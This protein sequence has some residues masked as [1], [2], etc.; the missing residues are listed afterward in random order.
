MRFGLTAC[1]Y[2][3]CLIMLTTAWRSR[4]GKT[5]LINGMSTLQGAKGFLTTE[6][7]RQHELQAPWV[8]THQSSLTLFSQAQIN[9]CLLLF[10]SSQLRW[11]RYVA[12]QRLALI[13][14]SAKIWIGWNVTIILSFYYNT[15]QTQTPKVYNHIT[16]VVSKLITAPYELLTCV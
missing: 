4:E 16:S 13:N 1:F 3:L 10:D 6:D 15:A 11:N 9:V 12:T 2:T 8:G 5:T 7:Q 14:I